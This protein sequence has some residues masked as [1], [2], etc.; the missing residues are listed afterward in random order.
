MNRSLS[1]TSAG[2]LAH[3]ANMSQKNF[4][5][6]QANALTRHNKTMRELAIRSK[7]HACLAD[8]GTWDFDPFAL[9]DLTKHPLV[10]TLKDIFDRQNFKNLL[11]IDEMKFVAFVKQIEKKY[12]DH[13]YHNKVHAADVAANMFKKKK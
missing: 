9:N 11:L 3:I 1:E 7:I 2:Q 5:M 8:L 10:A 12:E 4:Q 13:P 6:A